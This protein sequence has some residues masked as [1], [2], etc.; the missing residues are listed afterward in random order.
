MDKVMMKRA[1]AAADCPP[2]TVEFRDGHDRCCAS[3][4]T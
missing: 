1:F 4:R 3:R 2:R